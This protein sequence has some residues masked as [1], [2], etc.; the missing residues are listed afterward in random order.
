MRGSSTSTSTK[1]STLNPSSWWIGEPLEIISSGVKV[2][3]HGPGSLG[4]I[5]I[6][7]ADGT[8]AEVPLPEIRESQEEQEPEKWFEDLRSEKEE[9]PE[10]SKEFGDQLD[11]HYEAL[12]QKHAHPDGMSILEFQ[13]EVCRQFIRD[14]IRLKRPYI[15]I[16]HG[17]GAGVLKKEVESLLKNYPEAGII[18]F[19]TFMASVDVVLR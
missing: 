17:R 5:L 10:T 16:I 12:I 1:S 4:N 18:S 15:R 19:N 6:R 11:L 13:L 2:R 8:I 7:M 14:A 9:S 3:Y